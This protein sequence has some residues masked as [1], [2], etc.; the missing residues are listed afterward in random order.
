[1]IGKVKIRFNPA[2][3]KEFPLTEYSVQAGA[4]FCFCCQHFTLSTINKVSGS[5]GPES[6]AT[7]GFNRLENACEDIERHDLSPARKDTFQQWTDSLSLSHGKVVTVA[8]AISTWGGK[9]KEN[10]FDYFSSA[11]LTAPL[12]LLTKK[13]HY[14]GMTRTKSHSEGETFLQTLIYFNDGMEHFRK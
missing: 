1:M 5:T 13:W 10:R 2:T 11:L 7:T 14:K 12:H 8:L 6:F 3:Y 9:H 4:V